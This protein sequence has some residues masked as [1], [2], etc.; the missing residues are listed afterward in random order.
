M[1]KVGLTGGI[2]CGKSTVSSLFGKWGAY[3]LDADSVAKDI[4]K[5]NGTAQGEVIAEFGTDVLD[6]NGNIDKPKLAR[7]AFQDENH[8]LRLNAIIHPY[9]FDKIDSSFD[10]INSTKEHEIFIID[11]ALIY[12]S[13][14]DTHMDYVIVV[15][16]HLKLR[17]QRVMERGGLTREEFLKRLE[18]QWPDEDKVHMADFVIHNNSTEKKLSDEARH[19]FNLLA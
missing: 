19:V 3:I 2:G 15:T 12:E 6:R 4:L 16:S 5:K 14:A 10:L 7:V 17:T 9:V 11:A 18:L 1:I 13:G 8:Q